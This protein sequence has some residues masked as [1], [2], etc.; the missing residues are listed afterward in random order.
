VAIDF[1][2]GKLLQAGIRPS[3]AVIEVSPETVSRRNF[4]FVYHLTRQLMWAD[5]VNYLPDVVYSNGFPRLIATR[6]TPVYFFRQEFRQ[7]AIGGTGLPTLL[8]CP[9]DTIAAPQTQAPRDAEITLAERL[10]LGAS[11]TKSRLH[12]FQIGGFSARA[13]ERAV[14]RYKTLGVTT[15]LLAVSV[16]GPLRQAYVPNIDAAFL[17]FME[18]LR[19]MY[20]V[21]FMDYRDRIPDEFFKS[22]YYTT[23]QGT[24]YVTRLLAREVL[25]PLWQSKISVPEASVP[26]AN[27]R[28]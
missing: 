25:A 10:T 15:I 17:A 7:W 16:S 26:G 24:L 23:E 6:F 19:K 18:R 21:Y 12:R 11:L 27:P 13:L 3:L 8:C 1:L 28:H 20:G 4:A 22:G 14:E 9:D 2:V 5:V